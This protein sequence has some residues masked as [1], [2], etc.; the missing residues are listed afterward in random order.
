M[1]KAIQV[2]KTNNLGKVLNKQTQTSF[3][4]LIETPK[5]SNKKFEYDKK[6]RIIVYNRMINESVQCPSDCGFITDTH[7]ENGAPLDAL[8]LTGESTFPG[9]IIEVKPIGVLNAWSET[10][11]N[12]KI[13]CV[14]LYDSQWNHI[15]GLSD[16]PANLLRK[17]EHFFSTNTADWEDQKAAIKI[18]NQA[19]DSFVKTKRK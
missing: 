15:N 14:P 5:V 8:V 12:Q 4:V 11:I 6:S 18:I 13:L 17:I 1:K 7:S 3:T 16:A 2:L 19:Q 9:C 10:K